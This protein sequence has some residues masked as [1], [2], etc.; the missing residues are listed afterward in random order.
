[1]SI[2]DPVPQQIRLLSN[3]SLTDALDRGLCANAFSDDWFPIGSEETSDY[4]R[5]QCS[6]CPVS[7]ECLELAL[8]RGGGGVWGGTTTD[9]RASIRRARASAA[10]E[11]EA[12]EGAPIEDVA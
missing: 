9:E 5:R 7:L 11:A 2:T 6:G 1:M 4:A 12:A 8:R 3:R 10:R